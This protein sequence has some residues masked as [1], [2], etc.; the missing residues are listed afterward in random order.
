MELDKLVINSEDPLVHALSKIFPEKTGLPSL[1][2]L[3]FFQEK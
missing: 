3:E 2:K 1:S